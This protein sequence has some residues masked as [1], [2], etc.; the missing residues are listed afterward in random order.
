MFLTADLFFVNGMPFFI[1]IIRKIDFTEISHL[2]GRKS[3][4][5]FKDFKMNFRLYLQSGFRI[6][7]LRVDGEFAALQKFI[8][9]MPGGGA[10]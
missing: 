4:E 6:T 5:I 8:Q 7:T 9:G 10:D 3:T 2:S 1:S